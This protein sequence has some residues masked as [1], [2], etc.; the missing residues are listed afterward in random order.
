[1]GKMT[2]DGSEDRQFRGEGQGKAMNAVAARRSKNYAFRCRVD[3][4]RALLLP[5]R[6]RTIMRHLL[7]PVLPALLL[8]FAGAAHAAATAYTAGPSDAQATPLAAQGPVQPTPP[9]RALPTVCA[10][11]NIAVY[12]NVDEPMKLSFGRDGALYAG[13][14]GGDRIHRIAP[15]GSPVTEFGPPM[16]DPDAVLVDAAGVISGVRNAVLVGGGGILAAI[17]QDQTSR[18]IFNSGFADVDDMKFDESRRLVFSDDAPQVLVSQGSPPT[19]LF[20]TP[21]RPGS[22]AI[23]D[24]NRIFVALGDGTIRIYNADGSLADSAF[25]SGLAGLDTYLAFGRGGDGF[26]KALYVLSGRELLRFNKKGK[27]TVIGSGFNIGPSSGTGFVFGPD[28]ALYVSDYYENR[29][30]KISRGNGGRGACRE[31]P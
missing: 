5:H 17:F 3:D 11:F 7:S 29:V 1:M 22:I 30:L 13:R 25:A 23:D 12:S 8:Y 4:T 15:G 9:A 19:V 6:S 24:D 10:G 31:R 20:A 21:S 18:V 16:V 28:K 27:A 14:Q 26:G 2:D